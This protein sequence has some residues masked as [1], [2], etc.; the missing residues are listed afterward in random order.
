MFDLRQVSKSSPIN[1]SVRPGTT[2]QPTT[3]EAERSGFIAGIIR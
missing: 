2:L 1:Q 3:T